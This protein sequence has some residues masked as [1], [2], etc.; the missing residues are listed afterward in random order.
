MSD[1]YEGELASPLEESKSNG[2]GKPKGKRS[3][4]TRDAVFEA[5]DRVSMGV[6]SFTYARVR[7]ALGEA[8]DKPGSYKTISPYIREWMQEHQTQIAL[9]EAPDRISLLGQNLVREIWRVAGEMAYKRVDTLETEF[10]SEKAL[11]LKN[12]KDYETEMEIQ[13]GRIASLSE[14]NTRFIDDVKNLTGAKTKLIGDLAVTQER[15][16]H[17]THD[18]KAITRKHEELTGKYETLEG[19]KEKATNELSIANER[20]EQSNTHNQTLTDDLM[21][22]GVKVKQLEKD[23]RDYS[24]EVRILEGQKEKAR[25]ELSVSQK[26]LKES[27]AELRKI[28]KRTGQQE[29]H[30]KTLG[31]QLDAAA[32]I[33]A[34]LR[35]QV[36][37]KDKMMN[38]QNELIKQLEAEKGSPE[39][40]DENQQDLGL[41]K[42]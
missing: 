33:N 38:T 42:I 6:E 32:E 31:R 27:R 41:E 29:E 36:E 11:L 40:P 18:L 21:D 39:N 4:V 2:N 34:G 25:A 17:T 5:C 16:S 15:L 14:Q 35:G 28:T 8:F 1:I 9:P 22:S 12:I 3:Q 10:D 24:K 19:Q 30:I 26:A 20:L 23:N 7:N 37:S 13:E